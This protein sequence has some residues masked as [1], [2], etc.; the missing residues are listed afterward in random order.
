MS[1]PEDDI[2][3]EARAL[4]REVQACFMALD[5]RFDALEVRFD[6]LAEKLDAA[7]AEAE[8]RHD[9]FRKAHAIGAI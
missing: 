1:E 8:K 5:R 7:I 3:A 2:V 9:T 4:Q 6:G